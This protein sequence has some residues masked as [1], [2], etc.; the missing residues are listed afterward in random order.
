MIKYQVINSPV[1]LY[2][3]L[4]E[5]TAAQAQSRTHLLEHV[6]NNVFMIVKPVNFK[7][8]E[9]ISYDGE[10]SKALGMQLCDPET[11]Q[12]VEES[13]GADELTVDVKPKKSKK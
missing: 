13:Q 4:L 5:L 10:L 9:I 8:G 1:T 3:G 2:S 6:E 12:S 11:V 7:V